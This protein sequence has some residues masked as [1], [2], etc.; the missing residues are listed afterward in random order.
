MVQRGISI[1]VIAAVVACPLYCM[2]APCHADSHGLSGTSYS[3]N[4]ARTGGCCGVAPIAPDQNGP[5][6]PSDAESCQGICSGAVMERPIGIGSVDFSVL[7]TPLETPTFNEAPTAIFVPFSLAYPPSGDNYG[8]TV[9][10]LHAS[11]LC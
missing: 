5:A 9:R 11:F 10:I 1:L 4:P 6:Q 3:A 8:R 7:L 2:V